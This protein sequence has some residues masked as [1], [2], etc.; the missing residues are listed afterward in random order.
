MRV[1]RIAMSERDLHRIEV[2]SKIFKGRTTT[3]SAA[4]ILVLSPRRVRR[5]LERLRTNGAAAIRHKARGRPSNNRIGDGVWD[6]ALAMAL[7]SLT[8]ED[9]R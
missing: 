5:L 3:V 6:Y 8:F 9:C 4:D 7:L 2:L 1:G